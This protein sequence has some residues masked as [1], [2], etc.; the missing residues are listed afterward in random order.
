MLKDQRISVSAK[1]AVVRDG[2]LLVIR[3]DQPFLHYNLPGGRLVNG[4]SLREAVVRKLDEECAASVEVTRLLF[5]FEQVVE[6]AEVTASTYQ[7]VQFTFECKLRPGSEPSLPSTK[8]DQDGVEWLPLSDLRE[9]PLLPPVSAK[10]L[11]ALEQPAAFDP[12]V[13]KDLR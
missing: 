1:G 4:E 2:S 3:Y 7:K 10:L 5:V 11:E 9:A 8:P 6:R 12:Q 13:M